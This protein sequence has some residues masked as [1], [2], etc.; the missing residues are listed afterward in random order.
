M[1][2]MLMDMNSVLRLDPSHLFHAIQ[3]RS[4]YY[5]GPIWWLPLAWRQ[6]IRPG[7]SENY[8]TIRIFVLSINH[9]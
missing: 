1:L 3:G 6:A 9:A 7:S 4:C 2:E 8:P 5:V